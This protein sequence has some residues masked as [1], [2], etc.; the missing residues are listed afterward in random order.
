[1][2]TLLSKV[3]AITGSTTTETTD[4]QVVSFL[5][6]G[7]SYAVSSIPNFLLRV[8][9]AESSDISNDSGY[10][11]VNTDAI[12]EVLRD[13]ATAEEVSISLKKQLSY[14]GS[15]DE[16][17]SFFPKYFIQAN[18]IYI[19]PAPNASAVGNVVYISM[20]TISSTTDEGTVTYKQLLN[21]IINY[22]AFLDYNGLASYW[23]IQLENDLGSSG[24]EG[25]IT[26]FRSTLPSSFSTETL[27]ISI[28]AMEA[29]IT[30]ASNLVSGTVT[31]TNAQEWIDEEDSEMVGASIQTAATELSRAKTLIEEEM[32]KLS[33]LSKS[34]DQN[35]EE[36]KL[37]LEKA[38]A[39]LQ[40]A[41]VR[42]QA[43]QGYNTNI[44]FCVTSAK[45]MLELAIAETQAYIN[46]NEDIIKARI[47]ATAPEGKN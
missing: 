15:L 7:T 27:T 3:R 38:L 14:V 29:A 41:N 8:F 39:Y 16:A 22:A 42:I 2:S 44:T 46:A 10:T 6:S 1:M 25:A 23:R 36:Y 26:L 32:S 31:T 45:T 28:T 11:I 9:A 34:I 12:L 47:A 17:T 24:I 40:E 30:N 35:V 19:K 21:I 4:I 20:P 5:N 18:K 37:D 13:G 43:V 33:F